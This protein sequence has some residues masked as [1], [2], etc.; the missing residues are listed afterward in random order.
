[1]KN[2]ATRNSKSKVIWVCAVTMSF[3]ID[4]VLSGFQVDVRSLS[5]NFGLIWTYTEALFL[6]NTV[7]G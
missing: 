1:M 3:R 5:T 7:S 6:A 2:V 4:S